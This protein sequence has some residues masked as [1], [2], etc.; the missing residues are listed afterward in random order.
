MEKEKKANAVF[1]IEKQHKLNRIA[2]KKW[3]AKKHE[4]KL[5]ELLAKEEE[6]DNTME[7]NLKKIKQENMFNIC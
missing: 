2:A 3:V 1:I 4:E 6:I 7:H 5:K